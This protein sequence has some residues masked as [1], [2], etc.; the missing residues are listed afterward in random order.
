MTGQS[1]FVVKAYRHKEL[2]M[3]YDVSGKTFRIW[4]QRVPDLGEY[5]GKAYTP[6]QV[7]KIVKH[8]GKP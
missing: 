4:L 2:R 7:E 1:D 8:L 3:L 6:E 5:K